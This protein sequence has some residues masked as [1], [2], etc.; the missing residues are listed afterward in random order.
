M[1]YLGHRLTG[2]QL[3]HRICRGVLH[4]GHRLDLAVTGRWGRVGVG[5]GLEEGVPVLDEDLHHHVSELDVH[6]GGHRLF[7]RPEQ[8]GAEADPEVRHRHQVLVALDGGLGE[9]TEEH[10]QHPVVGVGQLLDQAVNLKQCCNDVTARQHKHLP[11][12]I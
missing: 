8:G 3:N 10:L 9:V 1:I 4:R 2:G 5:L 6:D 12:P 7:L 11:F